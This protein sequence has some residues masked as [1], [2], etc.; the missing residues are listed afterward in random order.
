MLK[1]KN[2]ICCLVLVLFIA[3][4]GVAKPMACHE[5]KDQNSQNQCIENQYNLAQKA[6]DALIVKA[7][8]DY[9]TDVEIF[10]KHLQAWNGFRKEHCEMQTAEWGSGSMGNFIYMSCMDRLTQAKIQELNAILNYSK[11]LAE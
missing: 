2:A 11:T 3:N 5:Q 8:K 6:L 1:F 7:T 4:T 9:F 10:N